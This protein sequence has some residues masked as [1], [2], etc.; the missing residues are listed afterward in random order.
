MY[1][2]FKEFKQN[3]F[4][5]FLFQNHIAEIKSVIGLSFHFRKLH[6]TSLLDPVAIHSTLLRA[7]I[8]KNP[9]STRNIPVLHFNQSYTFVCI[10]SVWDSSRGPGTSIQ[11]KD[12]MW[13]IQQANRIQVLSV[14]IYIFFNF[15][16]DTSPFCG[17]T[18]T[19]VLDF[20]WHLLWVLKPDW[21]LPYLH[22]AEVYMLHIHLWC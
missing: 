2:Y 6:C 4:Q 20:W 18:Y 10:S 16:E 21:V 15:L 8:G 3:Y 13:Q 5:T 11:N 19:P 14:Y 22:L 1:F 7:P 17:A 9:H 12:S